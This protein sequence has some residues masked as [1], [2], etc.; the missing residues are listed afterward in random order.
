MP[1][2]DNSRI[3]EAAKIFKLIQV[4]K[5]AHQWFNKTQLDKK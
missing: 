2:V 4:N 1:I 5:K 3:G